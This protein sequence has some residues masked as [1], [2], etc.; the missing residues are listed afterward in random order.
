MGRNRWLVVST[1]LWGFLILLALSAPVRGNDFCAEAQPIGFGDFSGSTVGAKADGVSNCG[2]GPDVW[3]RYTATEDEVIAL[4]FDEGSNASLSISVHTGCS[5]SAL[6]QIACNYGPLTFDAETG[7]EYWIRIGGIHAGATGEF[8]LLVRRAGAISGRVTSVEGEPIAD[9]KIRAVPPRTVGITPFAFRLNSFTDAEGRYRLPVPGEGSYTVFTDGDENALY[10]DEASGDLPCDGS[11]DCLPPDEAPEIVVADEEEVTGIDFQLDR[12]GMIRGRV[13]HEDTGEA[14]PAALLN[15]GA[16]GLS[17]GFGFTDA[18]GEYTLS[19]LRAGEYS[20]WAG[21][22]GFQ[23]ELWRGIPCPLP[24]VVDTGTPVTVDY[25]QVVEGID[26][27]L[28]PQASLRG[29]VVAADDGEPI[30]FE[31][32]E[33]IRDGVTVT[34]TIADSNGNYQLFLEPGTYAVLAGTGDDLLEVLHP[35]IPCYD[36]C[37]FASGS[38]FEVELRDSVEGVDFAIER[39]SVIRGQVTD[40]VTGEP[41][42][43]PEITVFAASSGNLRSQV[44]GLEDGTYRIEQLAPGPYIVR[45]E[46]PRFQP[47]LWPGTPCPNF[48]DLDSGTPV[49][50]EEAGSAVEGISFMLRKLGTLRGQVVDA[51]TGEGVPRPTIYIDRLFENYRG[52][53]EGHFVIDTVQPGSRTVAFEGKGFFAEVYDDLR[54]PDVPPSPDCDFD[55]GAP[56]LV[57]LEDVVDLGTIALDWIGSIEGTVRSTSGTPVRGARIEVYDPQGQRVNDSSFSNEAGD[58]VLSGL[59]PGSYHVVANPL[60]VVYQPQVWPARPC[61]PG[62][63][64]PTTGE[65]I[66]VEFGQRTRGIDFTVARLPSIEGTVVD[67]VFGAPIGT[68][69]AGFL[70]PI[71]VSIWQPEGVQSASVDREGRYQFFGL[72]PGNYVLFTDAFPWGFIDRFHDGGLCAGLCE[73]T[74]GP[75]LTVGLDDQLEVD[76]VLDPQQGVSGRVLQE[77]TGAPIGEMEID[78]WD[79]SGE[80]FTTLQTDRLGRFLMPLRLGE[81]YLSTHNRNNLFQGLDEVYPDAPCIPQNPSPVRADFCD[82]FDGERIRVEGNT[83]VRDLDFHLEGTL[84]ESGPEAQCLEQDRFRVS[85]TTVRPDGQPIQAQSFPLTDDTAGFT[86]FDPENLEV[87]VKVVNTCGSAFDSFWVFAAGLTGL[88]TRVEVLDTWSRERREYTSEAGT[89]FALVRDTRAF[90]TC[91]VGSEAG[92]STPTPGSS[93]NHSPAAVDTGCADGDDTLCLAES[94]FRLEVEWRTEAGE[95]GRGQAVPLGGDSGY[96]WFFGPQNVEIIAKVIDACTLEPFNSF[97]FFAAGLTD[98]E[99]RLV[100]TDTVSG[101]QTIYTNRLGDPF[102]PILD[103]RAFETCSF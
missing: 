27:T 33:A 42:A 5:G 70:L 69:I 2:S 56:I 18:T 57:E 45:V 23:L 53:E 92:L 68:R 39:R 93:V 47:Q 17:T 90:E 82:P 60:G 83:L 40:A 19:G 38:L 49:V 76:F 37:D 66:R 58:F 81:Y 41:V 26:F 98:V 75:L 24:C 99:T 28:A 13:T 91:D 16:E 31:R 96:F 97:W 4:R 7:T 65:L 95:E 11:S 34:S 15:A 55:A 78:V 50:I 73:P 52:D 10:R 100:V 67:S 25:N 6:N 3:F 36:G 72:E 32:V 94:R 62:A 89:P 8:E 21:A 14:M 22:F 87:V 79:A 20:V 102:E 46:H 85:V 61:A 84:C 101:E 71:T 63:C 74:S 48:C 43:F 77:G 1:S 30:P 35:N 88:E 12:F 54:C 44:T 9:L 103:L 80:R 51:A 29:R 86:F 59:E 64:D